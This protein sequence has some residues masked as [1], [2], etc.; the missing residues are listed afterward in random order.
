[1]LFQE[2]YAGAAAA[3]ATAGLHPLEAMQRR[4]DEFC[5]TM[6]ARAS[7]LGWT[8]LHYAA[9]ADSAGAARALLEAGADPTARD[10]A[11][12]RALHYA[13]DPSPARDLIMQVSTSAQWHY[14]A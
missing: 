8:A 14:S 1:M 4:E 7:F 12:R 2:R 5:A 13:R 11:G 9:L 3:A 10:H 6:N